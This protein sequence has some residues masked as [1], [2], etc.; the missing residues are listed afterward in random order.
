MGRFGSLNFNLTGTL[1]DELI[2][3]PGPGLDPYDCVGFYSSVCSNNSVGRADA[4]MASPVP[5]ELGRRRGTSTCRSPGA[6]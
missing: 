3:D 1:L 5:H 6:T 4:G 2:T